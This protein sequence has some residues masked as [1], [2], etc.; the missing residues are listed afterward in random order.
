MVKSASALYCRENDEKATDHMTIL[1]DEYA[2]NV[3][4]I[5]GAVFGD[6]CWHTFGLKTRRSV[7]SM[8]FATGIW[9]TPEIM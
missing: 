9:S 7:K 1:G 5:V 8:V 3:Q 4:C 2:F 6:D